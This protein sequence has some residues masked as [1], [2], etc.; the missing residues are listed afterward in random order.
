MVPRMTPPSGDQ[1]F[2][3]KQLSVGLQIILTLI[4]VGSCSG[5]SSNSVVRDEVGSDID[6]LR[7]DVRRLETQVR[8]LRREVA[9]P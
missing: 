9:R 3:F 2:S 1:R 5:G 6:A 8:R 4:L 7:E